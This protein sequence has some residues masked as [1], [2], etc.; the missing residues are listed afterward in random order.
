VA[1]K[2]ECAAGGDETKAGSRRPVD[3]RTAL[4][5]LGVAG[6]GLAT[7]AAVKAAT[8]NNAGAGPGGRPLLR[9][10]GWGQA[11]HAC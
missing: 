9:R 8:G 5:A 1:E 6:V 11:W 3:R 4:T 2:H 7:A 10:R